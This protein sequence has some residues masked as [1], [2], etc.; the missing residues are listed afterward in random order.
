MNTEFSTK[1]KNLEI[2]LEL[3]E[4]NTLDEVVGG[5]N[6]VSDSSVGRDKIPLTRPDAW[7][8]TRPE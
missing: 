2:P 5:R 7:S 4:L 1:S 8:T 6:E 3:L